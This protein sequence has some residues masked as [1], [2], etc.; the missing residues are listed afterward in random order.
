MNKKVFA[1]GK[2]VPVADTVN[3]AGGKAYSFTNEQALAQ[4]AATGCMNQTFYSS[5]EDQF[6]KVMKLVE[7][8][9]PLFVAKT[10]VYSR[11]D[12]YM[13][14]MPAILAAWLSKDNMP[15]L[16]K[17]FSKVIDNG[18]MLRNFVQA[19]RSGR[20]GRTSL[21][22]GPRKLIEDW[23]L[24]HDTDYIFRN[25]IGNDPSFQII[26]KLAHPRHK[27][28][29]KLEHL[30]EYLSGKKVVKT[31]SQMEKSKKGYFTTT[32]LK[33]LPGLVKEYEMFKA[34]KLAGEK[35]TG[36][37]D[38]PFQMLDS[39]I[40]NEEWKE[41]ARNAPWH[42]TRM[43]LNTFA[44]HGVFEKNGK[45]NSDKEMIELI[46]NRLRDET[47]IRKVK[48]FPY[49]LLAAFLNVG[50]DIPSEITEALQDALDISL[51]NIPEIQ[52]NIVICPDVSGSMKSA[53][54]G[55]RKGST[56]K[57]RCVDIAALVA[58]AMLRVN[59]NA[60]VL[61]FEERVVPIK[62]N[63]RDSVMTNAQKLAAVGGGGTCCA[64]PLLKLVQE[65][66]PVDFILFISDN[67][68]WVNPERQSYGWSHR[69]AGATSVMQLFETL[70]K[71]NKNLKMACIDIQPN[72]ST[73]APDNKN[74]LN[75]G[76]FSDS[77]FDV[78]GK[79]ASVGVGGDHWVDVIKKVEI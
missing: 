78:V 38:V 59:K 73:Q 37:P 74:I 50:D 51:S 21:G 47:Q 62:M 22:N 9:D 26:L 7:G 68:S 4:F 3:E 53:V 24:S 12:G 39:L 11:K 56:S 19:I 6:E 42:M 1:N 25:S 77:V 76:G 8:V 34:A 64:A 48:V 23:F 17:I 63:P 5:E 13:K 75:I 46:A 14:D 29:K 45:K 54:T 67:E 57:I 28:N 35:M 30:F 2:V 31:A 32:L 20:V 41:I 33:S 18:K 60:V 40:S 27:G 72:T 52:G 58:A 10:A 61:P 70:K 36:I 55:V 15:L 44:R 65:K 16:R 49:Q 69:N 79:F 71:S 43:N 66:T